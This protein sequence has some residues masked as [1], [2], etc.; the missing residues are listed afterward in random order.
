MLIQMVD[1]GWYR[2]FF[3][4]EWQYGTLYDLL[5]SQAGFISEALVIWHC[6]PEAGLLGGKGNLGGKPVQGRLVKET[7]SLSPDE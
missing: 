2:S 6:G 5:S 3:Q 4:Q 1:Q 7:C